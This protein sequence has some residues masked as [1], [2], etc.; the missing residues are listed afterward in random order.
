MKDDN[1]KI[2]QRLQN[3]KNIYLKAGKILDELPDA[4]PSKIRV[5]LKEKILG[6]SD[7]KK[8]MEGIDEHRPPRLFLIGRTGV[9]KAL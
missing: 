2:E 3:M 6:D 4:I 1:V 7:L 5:T 9:G 8:L